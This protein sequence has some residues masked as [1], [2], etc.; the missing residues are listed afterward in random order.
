MTLQ[1]QKNKSFKERTLY[2]RKT[3]LMPKKTAKM[4]KTSS[5]GSNQNNK[6]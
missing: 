3:Y 4:D 2:S 5:A 1:L 6:N